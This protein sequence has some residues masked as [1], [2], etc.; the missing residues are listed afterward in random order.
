M[1]TRLQVEHPVTEQVFGVDLV[2]LQLHI[3]EGNPLDPELTRRHPN[4][5]S[6]EVRLYAEDCEADFF[7]SAGA[8][9]GAVFPSGSHIRVE[10]GI[11]SVDEISSSFD[12][13]FGK[14]ITTG[15]NRS[16]AIQQMIWALKNTFVPGPKTNIRFLIDLLQNKSFINEKLSTALIA[17]EK[18]KL[19]QDEKN[20]KKNYS[21][22]VETIFSFLEQM[23]I[24]PVSASASIFEKTIGNAFFQNPST[25]T[26]NETTPITITVSTPF[27]YGIFGRGIVNLDK[28]SFLFS[29]VKTNQ[30]TRIFLN[31]DGYNFEKRI[32]RNNY[33]FSTTGEESSAKKALTAPVNGKVIS[34]H[35]RE[36]DQIQ[37]QQTL[38]IIESMKMQFEIKSNT[39][40][41]LKKLYVKQGDQV[42]AGK[43]LVDLG[44]A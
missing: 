44:E 20:E 13:M 23:Q 1:N 16:Q 17:Q 32:D 30:G 37:L 26:L 35:C 40:G 28:I 38:L 14:I 9:Y 11:D 8:V 18:T 41:V 24:P 31:I 39:L 42:D 22:L 25:L 5:H 10:Q 12:P 19:N 36:N 43:K 34:I 15:T 21:K 27:P 2:A 29:C 33:E 6:I 7:P 4:G 3:A